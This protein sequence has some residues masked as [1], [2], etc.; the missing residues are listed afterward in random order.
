LH[1]SLGNTLSAEDL[2]LIDR[3]TTEKVLRIT[4][5]VR[6]RHCRQFLHLHKTQHPSG[7][8]DNSITVIN[9]R[10]VPLEEA[11]YSILSKGLNYAVVP[12]F[13][14]VKDIFCGVENAIRIL[15]EDNAEEIRQET[16][17]ILKD[18]RQPKI[19]LTILKKPVAYSPYFWLT[20]VTLLGTSDYNRKIATLLQDKAHMKLK[21][22]PTHSIE[23]NPVLLLKKALLAED[24]C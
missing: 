4:D 12:R 8:P 13:I 19:N 16:I 2:D 23:R 20:K 7:P 24:V 21:K 11:A 10:K 9:L 18:S 6:A 14:T 22:D 17:R 3:I 1:L 5:Y 15:P